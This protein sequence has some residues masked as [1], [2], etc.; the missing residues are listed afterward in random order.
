MGNTRYYSVHSL[1][2]FRL[3]IQKVKF[4]ICLKQIY[5]FEINMKHAYH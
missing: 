2:F 1:L 4:K 5:T 3:L